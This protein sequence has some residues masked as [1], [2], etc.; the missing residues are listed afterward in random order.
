MASDV[1]DGDGLRH[2]KTWNGRDGCEAVCMGRRG[3]SEALLFLFHFPC[4]G[5]LSSHA[6]AMLQ[7]HCCLLSCRRLSLTASA[8][9]AGDDAVAFALTSP[10][11]IIPSTSIGAESFY[12]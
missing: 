11:A 7:M 6:G 4:R 9:T 5:R 12:W 3:A 10:S 2:P 1:D 8:V